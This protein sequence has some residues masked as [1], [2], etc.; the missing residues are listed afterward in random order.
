VDGQPVPPQGSRSGQ[1]SLHPLRSAS[2]AGEVEGQGQRAA[3]HPFPRNGLQRFLRAELREREDD[4]EG[5]LPPR[6][7]GAGPSHALSPEQLQGDGPDIVDPSG[8][9]HFGF[10]V[11]HAP[12]RR[13]KLLRPQRGGEADPGGRMHA[14]GRREGQ[15]L[16]GGLDA[17]DFRL[18]PCRAVK[19]DERAAFH[20]AVRHDKGG[21]RCFPLFFRRGRL[22]RAGRRFEI[23]SPVR[24]LLD[25][26]RR[27]DEDETRYRQPPAEQGEQLHSHPD[28]PGRREV[29]A[30]VAQAHVGQSDAGGGQE[31]QPHPPPDAEFHPQCVGHRAF[32]PGLVGVH[33]D[34][35]HGRD[36]GQE[37]SAGQ[38]EEGEEDLF[39]VT[40]ASRI[41]IALHIIP[42]RK[43]F[44]AQRPLDLSRS[45]R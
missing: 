28:G 39:H 5:R 42:I 9:G 7:V 8:G 19:V 44:H 14:G 11:P 29:G 18:R 37:D 1:R 25:P 16:Q 20:G 23:E 31:A 27:V 10:Q 12:L 38:Q 2:P 22:R 3:Q 36:P 6:Q 45:W 30:A 34:E 21:T 24:S 13:R 43:E 40:V 17:G 32:D 15:L 41:G 35:Q 4:P 33:V 26:D